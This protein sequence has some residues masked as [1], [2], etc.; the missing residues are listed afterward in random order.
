VADVVSAGI[1]CVGAGTLLF[2]IRTG[3]S[4]SKL[5]LEHELELRDT[6]PRIFGA[7]ARDEP[8]VAMNPSPLYLA[9]PLELPH[10]PMVAPFETERYYLH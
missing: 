10:T 5:S 4:L 6:Q 2:Q 8:S 1:F 9:L 7:L 3:M